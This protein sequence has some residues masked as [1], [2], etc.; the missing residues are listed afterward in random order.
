MVGFCA[1][2]F[3]G[4]KVLGGVA[5]GDHFESLPDISFVKMIPGDRHTEDLETQRIAAKAAPTVVITL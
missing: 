4:F 2:G 3:S 1:T 5:S